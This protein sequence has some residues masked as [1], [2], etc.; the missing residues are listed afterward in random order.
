VP[1]PEAVYYYSWPCSLW[2]CASKRLLAALS[3]L[4]FPDE[5]AGIIVYAIH[6]LD[7]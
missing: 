1:S 4:A 7:Q 6:A 5:I 3:R 2:I